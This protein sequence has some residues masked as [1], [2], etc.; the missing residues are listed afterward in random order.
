MIAGETLVKTVVPVDIG[1]IER[2]GRSPR[3]PIVRV[4]RFQDTEYEPFHDQNSDTTRRW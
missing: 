4:R 3:T 2:K 1:S